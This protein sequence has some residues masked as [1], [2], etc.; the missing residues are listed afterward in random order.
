[1][2]MEA[3]EAIGTCPYCGTKDA[4]DTN[5]RPRSGPLDDHAKHASTG[6][7][8]KRFLNGAWAVQ[9]EIAYLTGAAVTGLNFQKREEGWLL[10]VKSFSHSRGGRVVAFFGGDSPEDCLE[11]LAQVA[12]SRSGVQWKQDL[13]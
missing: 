2:T 8:S 11:T 7:F 13:Y 5:G 4:W 3:M 1:M 10:V 9:E 6:R 12:T